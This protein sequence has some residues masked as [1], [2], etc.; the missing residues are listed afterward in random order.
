MFNINSKSILVFGDGIPLEDLDNIDK[1]IIDG[2]TYNPTLFKS[3][4]VKNYLEYS[5]KIVSKVSDLSVS[6]EIIADDN[7]NSIQQSKKLSKLGKN[8]S[9]KIPITF[10][11]GELTSGTITALVE[12]NI[13]LNITAIFTLEQIKSILPIIKDT[14]TILS[15]FAGRLYDIGV[16]AKKE[17]GNITNFVHDNSNCRVL[18]ASPRMSFDIISSIE[19][20]CDIITM[21]NNLIN[22]LNMIGIN[23]N[24]YSLETVKMFYNDA[25]KSSYKI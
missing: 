13:N 18:W 9:I 12:E 21:P 11:N 7:K 17:V 2:L 8:V 16:D 5:K 1:N 15:V 3:I 10:T 25:V 24:K 6:L 14:K 20:N 4:G 19:T 22:K 23:P